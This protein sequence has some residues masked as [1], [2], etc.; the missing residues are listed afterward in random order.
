MTKEERLFYNRKYYNEKK[1]YWKVRYVKDKKYLKEKSNRIKEQVLDHYSHKC[2]WEGCKITDSDM[3]QIDHIEGS[4]KKHK[5]EIGRVTLYDWLIKNN[6]P[7]GFRLHSFSQE[8]LEI[9]SFQ[10]ELRS[11]R[12]NLF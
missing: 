5:R 11:T 7:E 2:Q 3:L 8:S 10:D 6:F 1:E 9:F 12:S 4:G